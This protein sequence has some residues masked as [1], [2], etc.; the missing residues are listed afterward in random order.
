[1]SACAVLWPLKALVAS[2]S[3]S[4][5]GTSAKNSSAAIATRHARRE[6][7]KARNWLCEFGSG[8][9]GAASPPTHDIC[10]TC[11]KGKSSRQA[12]RGTP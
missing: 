10:I 11:M 12:S 8:L 9:S 6:S 2:P 7:L 5:Q 1:M 3:A 4:M